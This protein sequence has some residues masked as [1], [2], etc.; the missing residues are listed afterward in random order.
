MHSSVPK[1]SAIVKNFVFW[2]FISIL[3]V[4]NGN[5]TRTNIKKLERQSYSLSIDCLILTHE[6]ITYRKMRAM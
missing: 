3:I 6:V 1:R 4:P 5:L 2:Y